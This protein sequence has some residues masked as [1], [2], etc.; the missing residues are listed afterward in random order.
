MVY[1]GNEIREI[2]TKTVNE[3]EEH[4][5]NSASPNTPYSSLTRTTFDYACLLQ[6]IYDA[7]TEKGYSVPD[8]FWMIAE[9]KV[10]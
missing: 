8:L 5:K 4:I 9:L 10:K 2:L 6:A 1:L 3:Y 7:T